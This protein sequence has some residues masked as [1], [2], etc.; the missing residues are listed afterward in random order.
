MK[1]MRPN[2][3]Y[4]LIAFALMLR[5]AHADPAEPITDD[6]APLSVVPGPVAPIPAAPVVAAPDPAVVE[7]APTGDVSGEVTPPAEDEP[8]IT[9]LITAFYEFAKN[10]EGMAAAGVLLMLSIALLRLFTSDKWP[11]SRRGRYALLAATAGLAVLGPGLIASGWSW[12]LLAITL[13]AAMSATGAHTW[14]KDARQM[15]KARSAT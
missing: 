9:D 1:P 5:I 8:T 13:A 14:V 4:C 11:K 3:F 10:G 7:P 6:P 15:L 2:L 12:Q